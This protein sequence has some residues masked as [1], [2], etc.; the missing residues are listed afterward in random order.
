MTTHKIIVSAPG[1]GTV[2]ELFRAAQTSNTAYIY[3]NLADYD[4]SAL[5]GIQFLYDGTVDR[6]LLTA[7]AI[8]VV[9]DEVEKVSV[10]ALGEL[11]ARLRDWTAV[12][13]EKPVTVYWN[14]SSLE[15]WRTR[16]LLEELIL[17]MD[18]EAVY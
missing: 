7:S 9:F 17:L 2:A 6:E 11:R 5:E 18:P 8:T 4:L 10:R 13:S 1:T 16:E 14:L 12:H 3:W 15:P